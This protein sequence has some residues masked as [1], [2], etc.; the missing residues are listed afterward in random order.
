MLADHDVDALL[1]EVDLA[2]LT[3][4]AVGDQ[5][6]VEPTERLTHELRDR[7]VQAKPMLLQ[8]LQPPFVTLKNGMLMPVAAIRFALDLEDRGFQLRVENYNLV[9][10]PRQ[11]LGEDD[12]EQIR[13]WKRHLIAIVTAA[14]EVSVQ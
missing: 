6:C 9:V 10:D 2:G 11:R 14:D 13:R 1:T 3:I 7:L 5:L 4:H 8:R 12:R